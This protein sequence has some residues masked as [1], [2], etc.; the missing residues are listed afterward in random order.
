MTPRT[1]A[2]DAADFLPLKPV[3]FHIL[4]SLSQQPAHG[5]AIRQSVQARTGGRIQLW[6][7]TLYGSISELQDGGLIEEWKPR[8]VQD[9]LT[10]RFYR[11]TA[12]GGRVLRAETDR[13]EDLVGLARAATGRRR[14]T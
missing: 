1:P 5:Y 7:A 13:L 3:W 8:G 14:V 4:L 10:R 11:L 2:S 9:E 6:P 12:L